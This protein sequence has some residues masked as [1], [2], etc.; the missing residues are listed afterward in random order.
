MLTLVY[1]FVES[2]QSVESAKN[3]ASNKAIPLL[4]DQERAYSFV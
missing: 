3:I 4:E 2:T 1:L